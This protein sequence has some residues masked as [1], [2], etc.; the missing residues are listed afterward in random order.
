VAYEQTYR[1]FKDLAQPRIVGVRIR[2]D[3]VPERRAFAL[4]S[5]YRI[6]NKH[7]RPID[8]LFVDLAAAAFGATSA[9][10]CGRVRVPDRLAGVSR[11]TRVLFADSARGVYLSG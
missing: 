9:A 8:S 4:R 11:P 6:V 7:A 1:R 2:A 3:L 5:V 10:A